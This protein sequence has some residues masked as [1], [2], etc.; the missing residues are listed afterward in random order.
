MDRLWKGT[1][2]GIT[3]WLSTSLRQTVYPAG[4]GGGEEAFD[5]V[6]KQLVLGKKKNLQKSQETRL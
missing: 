5:R 3:E 2:L 4:I 1:E 6:R